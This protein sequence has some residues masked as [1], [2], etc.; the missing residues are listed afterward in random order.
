MRCLSVHERVRALCGEPATVAVRARAGMVR[1]GVRKRR[2]RHH[3]YVLQAKHNSRLRIK[4]KPLATSLIIK[5]QRISKFKCAILDGPH[6]S[7]GVP[8]LCT[9]KRHGRSRYATSAGK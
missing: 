6:T 7:V 8:E 9:C 1:R 5:C 4:T 3:L 2:H